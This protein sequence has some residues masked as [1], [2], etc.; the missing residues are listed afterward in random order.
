MKRPSASAAELELY[1]GIKRAIAERRLQPGVK[2]AEDALA[3][4]FKVSRARVRKVLLLLASDHIV[5]H[6]PNRGAFVWKPSV[7]EARNILAAR[8]LVECY[9]VRQS[10]ALI[11]KPQ[12]LNL[13]SILVQ[14]QEARKADDNPRMM[15][16]SGEFHSA[17]A[18]CAEN[19]ILSEFL[20]RLISQSYLIL[21]VYQRR[22][23]DICPQD[24]HASIVDQL[25]AGDSETAEKVLNVHFDHIEA[26]LNLKDMP[27]TNALDLSSILQPPA[28][29][30][31]RGET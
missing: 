31:F 6:E 14:E 13:R 17:L 15:R 12:I 3:T 30:Y 26:E 11:T 20:A 19:Q 28:V 21:A 16:L 18:E 1:R 22:D 5:R 27:E 9:L 25:E 2:L 29:P 8:R 23:V 10:A 7:S 24:D 4:L